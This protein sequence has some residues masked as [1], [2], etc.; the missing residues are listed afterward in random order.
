MLVFFVKGRNL[1]KFGFFKLVKCSVLHNS[2]LVLTI[3][4]FYWHIKY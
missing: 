2:L 4:D 3:Y 1:T